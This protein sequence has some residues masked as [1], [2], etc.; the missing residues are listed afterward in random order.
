VKI[1]SYEY[2]EVATIMILIIALVS[3]IDWACGRVM[4]RFV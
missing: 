2:P 1:K 4:R 3:L